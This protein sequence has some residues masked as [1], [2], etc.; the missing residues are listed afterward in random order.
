MITRER[1][2][3][4]RQLQ[5]NGVTND[6]TGL[7]M[8][9][10][11]MPSD[12]DVGDLLDAAESALELRGHLEDAQQQRDVAKDHEA[13]FRNTAD[14]LRAKLDEALAWIGRNGCHDPGCHA[15]CICGI[16]AT[17]ARLK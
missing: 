17:I 15:T 13:H 1:I 16:D 5:V 12:M 9:E 11:Y 14:D 6:M 3:E 8:Y 2:A 7:S 4:L 10:V